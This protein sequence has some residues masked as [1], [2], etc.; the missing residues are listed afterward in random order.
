MRPYILA[1]AINISLL[2]SLFLIGTTIRNDYG[3][4]FGM[5]MF[6]LT[7][8]YTLT[9]LFVFLRFIIYKNYW[10]GIVVFVMIFCFIASVYLLSIIDNGMSGPYYF[11][12]IANICTCLLMIS[13]L[14]FFKRS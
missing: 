3:I 7:I 8:I 4:F 2:I 1:T 9:G 5:C 13:L 10:P 11:V 14:L 6:L 12:L